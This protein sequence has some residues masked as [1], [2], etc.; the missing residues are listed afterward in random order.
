M[1]QELP[2]ATRRE[3]EALNKHEVIAQQRAASRANQRAMLTAHRNANQ[4]V[5]IILDNKATIRSSRILNNGNASKVRYSYI[6]QDGAEFDISDIVEAEWSVQKG[7]G[8]IGPEQRSASAN[9]FASSSYKSAPTSP[10]SATSAASRSMR[11]MN[12][13]DDESKAVNDVR[14]VDLV[15]GDQPNAS[16]QPRKQIGQNQGDVL[17]EAMKRPGSSNSNASKTKTESLEARLDRVLNKIRSGDTK[18]TNLASTLC[19]QTSKQALNA[20]VPVNGRVSPLGSGRASPGPAGALS[21]RRS[22]ANA[23]N[24]RT[25]PVNKVVQHTKEASIASQ[26]SDTSSS[27]YSPS[28]PVTGPTLSSTSAANSP[29]T[30]ATSTMSSRF[31]YPTD[32][33]VEHLSAIVGSGRPPVRPKPIRLLQPGL[34]EL[35]GPSEEPQLKTRT[36][37]QL[38]IETMARISDF[39]SVCP[40]SPSTQKLMLKTSCGT[41]PRFASIPL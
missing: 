28:T 37:Q 33:G 9:S 10:L 4:G 30:R 5:D 15:I 35:F 17:Q 21:G 3:Q 32:L 22:P 34:E 39:E 14:K 11:S 26:A 18:S 2:E 20:Q 7:G 40:D 8:E 29:A 12:T 6:D 41:A 1:A 38:H 31:I 19:K 25:T 23:P 24:G 27:A 13:D 36:Y 16:L